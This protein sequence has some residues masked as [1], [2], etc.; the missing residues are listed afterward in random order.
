MILILL[1]PPKTF[2]ICTIRL[3]PSTPVHCIVWAQSIYK[4]F[5]GAKEDGDENEDEDE[6]ALPKD[7][8]E[9]TELF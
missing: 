2:P 8:N 3:N 7:E 4:R 9:G 1:A 6:N 5:F